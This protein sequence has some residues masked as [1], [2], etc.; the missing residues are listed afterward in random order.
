MVRQL[1]GQVSLVSR[2]DND[3]I[4]FNP[5]AMVPNWIAWAERAYFRSPQRVVLGSIKNVATSIEDADLE[6]LADLPELQE[7]CVSNV[8]ISDAG[9]QHVLKLHSLEVLELANTAVQGTDSI[10]NLAKLKCLMLNNTAVTDDG[11]KH[12]ASLKNL[13]R[14]A[15]GDTRITDQA[16]LELRPFKA[17]RVVS[18]ADRSNAE[19]YRQVAK[20]NSRLPNCL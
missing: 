2:F 5:L 20:C 4:Q 11:I 17:R 19:R 9:L 3:D 14:L 18:D 13:R 12:L 7:L 6:I 8:P 10:R 1:G 15:L 16:I